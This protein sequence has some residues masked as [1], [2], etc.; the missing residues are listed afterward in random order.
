MPFELE[1]TNYESGVNI[2]VVGVG[3]GGN[4]A[5]NRMV[6]T[7]VRGVEFIAI[8]TDT[9]ALMK[10]SAARQIA[11][12]ER[13][14]KGKGAGS[15]PDLGAAAAEES[16]E[17][18]KQALEGADMV[19]IAAGMGGGTG[20]GA[21]PV[22]ARL[23]QEMGILTVGIVTKPFNFERK[24]RMDQ[25]E[26]GIEN[27]KQYVDSLIIIPNERLKELEEKITLMN[28]FQ[29]ADD[30]LC[31]G[32]QSITELINVPEY[33]NLDFADVTAIMKDAGYAHMGM[34]EGSGK[35]M[36]EDAAR[37]AI[38]SPLLETTISGA[39]GVLISVTVSPD[40]ALE[41]IEAAS[42]LI[43]DEAAED[44]TV[45][46][47]AAFDPSLEDTMKITI[48]ATGFEN[49]NEVDAAFNKKAESAIR[50]LAYGKKT[51]AAAKPEVK[52]VEQPK[53]AVKKPVQPIVEE[54]EKDDDAP[55]SEDDFNEI[56]KMLNMNKNGQKR[57]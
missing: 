57:N 54:E 53:P 44:A 32:V 13:C 31:H 33:I 18:I 36:A 40:I 41:E 7:G 2:K 12:G 26:A 43:S 9:Q 45:I 46:W 3:G 49:K 16:S 23:A 25:A 10:S 19:F 1:D 48:I 56:I 38:H 37:S 20:T 55:I 35:G 51:P 42:S 47:G 30:V 29:F 21:A 34:G 11:I 50:P 4:N 22:V 27:L 15:N 17:E 14:A 6:N 8:N 5:L 52:V 24:K 39:K 28:A